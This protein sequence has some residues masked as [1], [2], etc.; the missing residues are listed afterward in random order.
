M[1]KYTTMKEFAAKMTELAD[2]HPDAW[3][4]VS[5][6]GTSLSS[7][8]ELKEYDIS[9]HDFSKN[10]FVKDTDPRKSWKYFELDFEE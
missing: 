10:E 6:N 7:F 4:S 2:L 3:M 1:S 9:F 5:V 8:V